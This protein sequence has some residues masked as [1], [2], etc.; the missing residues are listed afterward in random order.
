MA[1]FVD[2]NILFYAF[3]ESSA[4]Q[5]GKVHIARALMERL[6]RKAE[7]VLSA[8]VLSE[9]SFAALR[10]TGSTPLE[11]AERVSQ[12]STETVLPIDALLVQLALQRVAQSRISYWDALIVEAA[13]RSGATVLFTEDMHH[14]TRYGAL[15]LVNPFL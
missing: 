2:T 1:A 6:S 10:K 12:L 11:I 8:Q 4:D 7:L 9:F 15:E 3:A 13:L 5:V 14:G